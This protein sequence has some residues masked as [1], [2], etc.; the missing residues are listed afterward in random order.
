MKLQKAIEI[1]EYKLRWGFYPDYK[2][3]KKAVRLLI[4]AGK[5]ELDNRSGSKY[6]IVRQLKSETPE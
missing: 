6:V 1:L 5:R 2:E 4:E 3:Y